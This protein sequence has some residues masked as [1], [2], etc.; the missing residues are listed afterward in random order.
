MEYNA[1]LEQQIIGRLRVDNPWWTEG[2]IPAFYRDMTPRLYMEIFYPLVT[3]LSINRSIV[4]MGPRRVGKTVMLYH[5]IQP[6]HHGNSSSY[7]YESKRRA[8]YLVLRVRHPL[9]V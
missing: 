3:D 2:E 9:S 1:L 7:T 8:T 4:L 6:Q 5:T